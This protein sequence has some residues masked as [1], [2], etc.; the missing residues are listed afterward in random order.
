METKM[1]V[2]KL[3]YNVISIE[4]FGL[5]FHQSFEFQ[6]EKLKQVLNI[7]NKK[8]KKKYFRI[9]F[10]KFFLWQRES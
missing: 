1:F 10:V 6:S 9:P 2:Q 3:F 8:R 7:K 4:I 5:S